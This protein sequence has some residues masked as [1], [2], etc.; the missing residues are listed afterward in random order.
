MERDRPILIVEDDDALRKLLTMVVR[1]ELGAEVVAAR[2][3]REALEQIQR[4]RPALVLV[5]LM[6]PVMD[7]LEVCRRVKSN[8]DTQGIPLLAISAGAARDE[9]LAASCDDFLFKPFDYDDLLG[10]MRHW[11]GQPVV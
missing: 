5:D 10:K 1:D 3:G 4:E 8:P 2:N 11:L 7:G 9:A 6:M